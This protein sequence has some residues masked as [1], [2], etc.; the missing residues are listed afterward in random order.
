[1]AFSYE[2]T[3]ES[4]EPPVKGNVQVLKKSSDTSVDLGGGSLY[5]LAGAQ[6]TLYDADGKNAGVLT[7]RA[8]GSSNVL[9]VFC[10]TYTLKETKASPGFDLDPETYTVTVK[11]DGAAVVVE[12]VEPVQKARIV[13]RK[14]SSEEKEEKA[15]DTVPI[16]G[17]VYGIYGSKED[18]QES[19]AAVGTFV[20]QEEDRKSVV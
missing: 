17:A 19:R 1:M 11:T 6:Y 15:P 2:S 12:S 13:L 14:H 16:T 9:T 4:A 10:G 20:V 8:D 18:A 7:T 3:A 5:S